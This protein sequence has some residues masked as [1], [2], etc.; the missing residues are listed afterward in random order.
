[1][2][3]NVFLLAFV[4][5]PWMAFAQSMDESFNK[6]NFKIDLS[7]SNLMQM[8]FKQ[9]NYPDFRVGVGY[10]LTDWCVAGVFGSFGF[11]NFNL[12]V[13]G[14]H[15]VG[16]SVVYVEQDAFDGKVTECYYHYG[17]TVEL[18]PVA[19]WMPTFQWID[20]YCRGELGFRTLK[21]HYQ[22]SYNGSLAM[23]VSNELLY[24]GSVGIAIN[25]SRNFGF[26]YE[27]AIDNLNKSVFYDAEGAEVL[28]TKPI[29]RFGLNV[30]FGGPKNWQR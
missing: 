29:H 17:L 14:E 6:G 1:M 7:Y 20:P 28:K 15:L 8:V 5:L 10:G 4:L 21:W 12:S 3:K 25:P 27:F 13:S 19:I 22:P 26:F 16:D 18:H 9:D 11:H 23:P 30:R 2:R 24:G